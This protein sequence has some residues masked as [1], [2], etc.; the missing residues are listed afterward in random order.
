MLKS[1]PFILRGWDI[2]NYDSIYPT[3]S[4]GQDTT[5]YLNKNKI[6]KIEP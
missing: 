6:I 1:F 5:V 2:K 3:D 4:F